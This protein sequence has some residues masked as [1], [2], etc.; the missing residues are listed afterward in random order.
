MESVAKVFSLDEYRAPAAQAST[1]EPRGPKDSGQPESDLE[2]VRQIAGALVRRLPSHVELSELVALGCLGVV[3]ARRR[4]DARRG[5]PFAAFAAMRIRGAMLDGMRAEDLV[6]RSERSRI[7]SGE[8]S[9][10][11]TEV[12]L[13]DESIHSLGEPVDERL[14][15]MREIAEL[16]RLLPSLPQRERMVL[17]QHFFEEVPLRLIGEQLGVTESR[18]CQI[19]SAAVRRLRAL[20]Q[21]GK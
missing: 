16:R 21:G 6:S 2:L 4:Y 18:V 8:C 12:E 13:E 9:A 10:S 19:V 7:R 11:A 5:V 17:Q 20:M 15:R 1:G 14:A 3:E